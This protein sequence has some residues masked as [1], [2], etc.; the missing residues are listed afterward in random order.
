[1]VGLGGEG[2]GS[3]LSG[4]GGKVARVAY[5]SG[6]VG[7]GVEGGIIIIEVAEYNSSSG[8]SERAGTGLLGAWRPGEQAFLVGRLPAERG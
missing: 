5:G 1:M 3:I 2:G 4:C 7:S 8:D 6:G